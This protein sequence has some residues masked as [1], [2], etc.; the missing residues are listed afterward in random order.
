MEN[1]GIYTPPGKKQ[2]VAGEVSDRFHVS[3]SNDDL[4]VTSSAQEKLNE[5]ISQSDEDVSAIR[6]YIGGGGC[7][8]LSSIL[9]LVLRAS[10]FMSMWSPLTIYAVLK[11]IISR[12]LV[13]KDLCLTMFLLKPAEQ[14]HAA[15]VVLQVALAV[16]ALKSDFGETVTNQFFEAR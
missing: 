8:G 2:T 5:I 12:K 16:A 1:V 9:F 13:V 3:L 6:N 10:A 14:V 4:D 15:A 7:G 11:S